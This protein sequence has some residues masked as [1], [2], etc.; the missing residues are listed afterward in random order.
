MTLNR[1]SILYGPH[2]SWG[3]VIVLTL[4]ERSTSF[5]GDHL[6]CV[7][8]SWMG[9]ISVRNTEAGAGLCSVRYRKSS[10]SLRD[11]QRRARLPSKSAA[12]KTYEPNK[13]DQDVPRC[14]LRRWTHR[15]SNQAQTSSRSSSR[16]QPLV[17]RTESGVYSSTRGNTEAEFGRE[18]N[19]RRQG[20]VV[21]GT[22]DL[23]GCRNCGGAVASRLFLT[24]TRC[25]IFN[26]L[27]KNFDD[28]LQRAELMWD[29]RAR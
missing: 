29:F 25:V 11:P 4:G 15:C 27:R 8:R 17:R 16:L 23:C 10:R 13:L 1:I 22:W 6:F 2:F 20:A 7:R 9:E 5:V 18:L 14:R 12:D 3:Q 26:F 28:N 21:M 19:L 24:Q